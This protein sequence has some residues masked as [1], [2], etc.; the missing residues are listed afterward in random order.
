MVLPNFNPLKIA[1]LGLVLTLIGFS[2]D[3]P[4]ALAHYPHDDIFAVETSPNYEQDQTLWIN[5]RGNLLK[6][7]DGGDS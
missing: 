5:V 2:F 1:V 7:E 4:T 6:S 3:V